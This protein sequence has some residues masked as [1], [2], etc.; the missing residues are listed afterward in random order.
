MYYNERR[1][2]HK[3]TPVAL[4]RYTRKS[5]FNGFFIGLFTLYRNADL[6]EKKMPERK[7]NRLLKKWY[8]DWDFFW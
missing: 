5:M 2:V 4:N 1:K 3:N 7:W 6:K 8:V